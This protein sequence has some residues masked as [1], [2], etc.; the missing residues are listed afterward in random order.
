MSYYRCERAKEQPVARH[1]PKTKTASLTSG[2]PRAG[3]LPQNSCRQETNLRR[4]CAPIRSELDSGKGPPTENYMTVKRP[5]FEAEKAPCPARS[6]AR[7]NAARLTQ[8]GP[9]ARRATGPFLRSVSCQKQRRPYLVILA[10]TPEPTVRP[11]SRIAKR[12][13][14][15]MAIGAISL[16]PMVTL[17]PGITISVPSGRITSPVTSVVRK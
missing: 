7:Q 6:A 10:T 3:G 2:F 5:C 14:S 1:F 11:P 8:K 12:R 9:A 13:P 4:G 17:S 15:S 16:T